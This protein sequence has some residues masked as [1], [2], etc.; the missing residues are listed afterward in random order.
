MILIIMIGITPNLSMCW[1]HHILDINKL[2]GVAKHS[3]Q[4]L[5]F[6]CTKDV[7]TCYLMLLW[8]LDDDPL[9]LEKQFHNVHL[10]VLN[11][12]KVP[13]SANRSKTC[14]YCFLAA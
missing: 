7:R 14:M 11:S 5:A 10:E 9:N 13:K 2:K 1:T 4:G 12:I 3:T 8:K 6:P